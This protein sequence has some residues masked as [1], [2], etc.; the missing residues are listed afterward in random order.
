MREKGN[1]LQAVGDDQPYQPVPGSLEEFSTDH[2]WGYT[3]Q[4]DGNCL[5]Y[6][7]EHPIWPVRR[8]AEYAFDCDVAS[9]Y[10][11]EFVPALSAA[12]NSAFLIEGSAVTV[13]HGQTCVI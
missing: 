8:A 5:E 7:V 3:R 2:H 10:G 4:R 12:P 6:Q 1:H 11:E 13:Y 9:V